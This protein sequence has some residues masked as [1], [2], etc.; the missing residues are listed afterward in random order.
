MIAPHRDDVILA[1]FFDRAA[2]APY[3][4]ARSQGFQNH[5]VVTNPTAANFTTEDIEYQQVGGEA[6]L[7]SSTVRTAPAIPRRGRVH[8]GA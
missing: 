3:S 2:N 6:L 4:R 5:D 7:A 8:G 1:G